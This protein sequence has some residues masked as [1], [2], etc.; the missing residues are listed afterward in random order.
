MNAIPVSGAK[1]A[2]SLM[3]F[4]INMAVNAEKNPITTMARRMP[5]IVET[6]NEAESD[7]CLI[8]EMRQLDNTPSPEQFLATIVDTSGKYKVANLYRRN[9]TNLSFGQSTLYNPK[10]FFPKRNVQF[11][12]NDDHEN[13]GDSFE[14]KFGTIITGTE[15]YMLNEEQKIITVNDNGVVKQPTFWVFNVHCP[16]TESAKQKYCQ[17]LREVIAKTAG[18]TPFI[19]GGDFNT[20][21][22]MPEHKEQLALFNDLQDCNS[23]W[24]PKLLGFEND[25]DIAHE[26]TGSFIGYSNDRV[27]PDI[28]GGKFNGPLDHIYTSQEFVHIETE[29]IV[30]TTGRRNPPDLNKIRDYLVSDHVPFVC[31]FTLDV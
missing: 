8:Q 29:G 2:F 11:W 30:A 15:F 22:D 10:K 4:N 7:I 1:I 28:S 3:S 12:G 27:V 9:P 26:C 18:D 25:V 23:V 13:C 19:I 16:L 20:F 31:K 24:K 21:T 14:G 17:K 6:I 5:P